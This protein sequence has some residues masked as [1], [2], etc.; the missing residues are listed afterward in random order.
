MLAVT[1]KKEYL[2]RW[3]VD[4]TVGEKQ[5]REI[6]VVFTCDAVEDDDLAIPLRG[7]PCMWPDCCQDRYL[8]RKRLRGSVNILTQLTKH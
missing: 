8:S 4:F 6:R 7:W 3:Q 1:I 2:T 5:E